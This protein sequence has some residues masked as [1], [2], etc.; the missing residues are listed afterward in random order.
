MGNNIKTLLASFGPLFSEIVLEGF[1][2]YRSIYA[3][4]SAAHSKLSR[5]SLIHDHMLEK[6]KMLLPPPFHFTNHFQRG[7][8]TF[9]DEA[10]VQFK[11]LGRDLMPRNYPT[12]TNLAIYE[13]GEIDGLS[14]IPSSL[15]FVT[16]GYV[17]DEFW[18]N[19]LG[20]FAAQIVQ[21]RATGVQR[22]DGVSETQ[23]ELPIPIHNQPYDHRQSK[24]RLKTPDVGGRTGT[25][26]AS[27]DNEKAR[28]G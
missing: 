2:E 13:S 14:G 12:T 19:P 24:A 1:K 9:G 26:S 20:V 16:I 6:A 17:P 18:L 3:R 21:H 4:S 7:V 11:R 22:L 27:G 5:A 28:A 10:V 15:P 25:V 8:F 23:P